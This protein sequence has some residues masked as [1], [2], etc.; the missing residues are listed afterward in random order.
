MLHVIPGILGC[1]MGIF[2]I[3]TNLYILVVLIWNKKART[4]SEW[5]LLHLSW[6]GFGSSVYHL[7]LLSPSIFRGQFLF[8]ASSVPF[9]GLLGSG[10]LVLQLLTVWSVCALS[11]D[12]AIA[13]VYPLRYSQ[14]ATS[15]RIS[16]YFIVVWFLSVGTMMTALFL[17]SFPELHT[18]YI[19]FAKP[20]TPNT[21]S[22]DDIFHGTDEL[23]LTPTLISP[24]INYNDSADVV[25]GIFLSE[26]V[27]T[28]TGTLIDQ[29]TI[30][31]PVNEQILVSG[32]SVNQSYNASSTGSN[33]PSPEV[34]VVDETY[35]YQ[36]LNNLSFEFRPMLGICLPKVYQLSWSSVLWTTEWIL[37]I[38]IAPVC[39]LLVC[40]L[41]VLSIAR[42]QSHRI[43][44]AMTMVT[45]TA[46]ATVT[47]SKGMAPTP[48]TDLWVN[49]VP[50]RSRACRAV[51]EDLSTL[52]LLHL[53][54][55][56]ILVAETVS[57]NHLAPEPLMFIG[58]LSMFATPS[59]N[60]LLYGIRARPLRTAYKSYLRKRLTNTTLQ[61]EIQNRLSP[62]DGSPR[63]SS[64]AKSFRSST[65]SPNSSPAQTPPRRLSTYD[66]R[67]PANQLVLTSSPSHDQ[68]GR[69]S[70]RR[71]YD[72]E[73][74]STA[75]KVRSF[76][77]I[78]SF[79]SQLDM[80]EFWSGL[81]RPNRS[82]TIV[83]TH[84]IGMKKDISNSIIGS[85]PDAEQRL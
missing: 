72:E 50:A 81:R 40:D 1:F 7:C 55:I 34:V 56:L 22:H 4:S 2:G 51:C 41:A 78:P 38:L 19:P 27:T 69:H 57:G 39:T 44:L 3:L 59:F 9:C 80:Q 47:R 68:F 53:P 36:T 76:L 23:L 32:S 66:L 77:H 85:P 31:L 20:V 21:P 54:F 13:I 46:Q 64:R 42:R 60:A 25:G 73:N 65:P 82:P 11:A 63:P 35:S 37:F 30:R 75:R 8:V 16:F 48:P 84:E 5:I 29:D 71:A 15:R 58:S 67:P 28:T 52:V 26:M 79:P 83:I 33:K 10:L 70:H 61:H 43:L 14:I 74:G 6:C 45:I 18:P 62:V 12:R 17:S 24:S 49:N